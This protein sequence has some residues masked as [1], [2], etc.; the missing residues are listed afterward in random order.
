MTIEVWAIAKGES[1]LVAAVLCPQCAD[2]LLRDT[3][4]TLAALGLRAF[5]VRAKA[6]IKRLIEG[7]KARGA[8]C[9][10]CAAKAGRKIRYS[11]GGFMQRNHVAGG[12]A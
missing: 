9:S 11:S 4:G 1:V 6:L 5:R 8:G 2:E 12:E 3:G 10:T 7:S